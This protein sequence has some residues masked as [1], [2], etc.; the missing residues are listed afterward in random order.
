MFLQCHV[1]SLIYTKM[2]VL[3]IFNLKQF[4]LIYIHALIFL[5]HV[6][7]CLYYLVI[8]FIVYI[9]YVVHR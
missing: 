7:T 3:K 2:Y 9:R 4:I 8:K 6:Y 5:Y 1:A